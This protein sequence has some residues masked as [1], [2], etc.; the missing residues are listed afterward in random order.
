MK[1]TTSHQQLQ[2]GSAFSELLGR[3]RAKNVPRDAPRSWQIMI[4]EDRGTRE[5]WPPLR[6]GPR[7]YLNGGAGR[8]RVA[9]RGRKTA[10]RACGDHAR[11]VARK[12][13]ER[14]GAAS[15]RRSEIR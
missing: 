7:S 13:D 15:D 9:E 1:R 10:P 11:D 6:F 8:D 2:R 12:P 5:L 14:F 4:S 3:Y